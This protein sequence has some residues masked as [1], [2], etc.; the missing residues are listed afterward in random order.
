[1]SLAKTPK[2]REALAQRGL[3]SRRERQLLILCDAR[4]TLDDMKQLMGADV[5]RD[6]HRLEEQGLLTY[7]TPTLSS[8]TKLAIPP[9]PG[10]AAATDP[11]GGGGL[12]STGI[13]SDFVW[14]PPS[15]L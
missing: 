9:A 6:I 2:G 5:E 13:E 1:M 11:G 12:M 4:R 7:I 14:P 15:R 10:R 8:R 3:L